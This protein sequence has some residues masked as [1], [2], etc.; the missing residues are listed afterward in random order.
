VHPGQ[1][2]GGLFDHPHQQFGAHID[3]A[4]GGVV[5]RHDRNAGR[6]ANTEKMLK[7]F[8]FRKFPLRPVKIIYCVHPT[9]CAYFA[10]RTVLAVDDAVDSDECGLVSRFR[11]KGVL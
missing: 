6:V 10:R 1:L 4:S 5:V 9:G 2:A 3:P 11:P 8:P 7:N